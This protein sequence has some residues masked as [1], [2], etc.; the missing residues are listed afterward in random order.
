MNLKKAALFFVLADFTAYSVWVAA[1]GGSL[2]EV[3]G[4]FSVNPWIG[5]V[6]LDLVIALSMVSVWI[7]RDAKANDR[8]PIPWLLATACIGSIAPLAYFTFRPSGE[9]VPVMDGARAA[10]AQHA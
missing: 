8:N 5:Q 6:T 3:L 7:Y 10:S 1:N 4:L 2:G 9:T